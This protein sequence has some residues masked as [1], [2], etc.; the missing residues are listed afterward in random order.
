[1]NQT[2]GGWYD[3][4]VGSQLGGCTHNNLD[5]RLASVVY[6]CVCGGKSCGTLAQMCLSCLP[7]PSVLEFSH[8]E[9]FKLCNVRLQIDCKYIIRPV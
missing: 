3:P 1:M 5:L 2:Q 7:L 6:E 9:L 8:Q 4:P